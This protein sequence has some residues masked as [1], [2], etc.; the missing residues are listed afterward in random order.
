MENERNGFPAILVL[1]LLAILIGIIAMIHKNTS[2]TEA[3]QQVVYADSVSGFTITEAEWEALQQEVADLRQEMNKIKRS[4]T[5]GSRQNKKAT[6]P[7]KQTTQQQP[8]QVIHITEPVAPPS[9]TKATQPE[10]E[11]TPSATQTPPPASTQKEEKPTISAN[12]ITLVNYTHDWVSR[13]AT[14]SLK[15]NTKK[16]ISQISGRMIYYDMKGNMLDYQDFTRNVEIDPGMTK[17][18]ELNGYGYND[19]YA[20]YKSKV[21]TTTPDRKYKVKFELKGYRTK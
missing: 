9:T 15:N 4:A 1:I 21:R 6:Q 7:T 14:L 5:H 19:G 3:S 16:T 13:E 17:S 20:Y 2:K 11:A 18:F 10:P 8:V 12:D